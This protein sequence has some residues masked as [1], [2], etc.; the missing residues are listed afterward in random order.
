MKI[1]KFSVSILGSS[2]TNFQD[3]NH[4]FLNYFNLGLDFVL[5]SNSELVRIILHTNMPGR[6]D[7]GAYNRCFFCLRENVLGATEN[8]LDN[9]IMFLTNIGTSSTVFI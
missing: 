7:F 2:F 6:Y 4:R 5:N 9:H 3:S 1:F 8:D